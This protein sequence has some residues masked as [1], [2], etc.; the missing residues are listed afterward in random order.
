[1]SQ[2]YPADFRAQFYETASLFLQC[3]D[4][5][6]ELAN[7]LLAAKGIPPKWSMPDIATQAACLEDAW[8]HLTIHVNSY[9][10]MQVYVDVFKVYAWFGIKLWRSAKSFNLLTL[11]SV[12][13]MA[14]KEIDGRELPLEILKKISFMLKN[15]KVKHPVSNGKKMIP[16]D[17]LAIGMNG[18]YMI[19]RA[20]SKLILPPPVVAATACT[21][22]PDTAP[23]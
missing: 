8:D 1:M 10:V 6:I 3:L 21:E 7:D 4:Q 12:M 20:C 2:L 13:N 15:D 23:A 22:E 9:S 18:L 17:E 5:Q 19:F 16:A 14:L 11:C